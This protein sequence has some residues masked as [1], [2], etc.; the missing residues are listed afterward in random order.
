[1]SAHEHAVLKHVETAA[2]RTILRSVAGSVS[3]V[4]SG[5]G[6]DRRGL[7]VTAATSLCVEPPMVL[8]C[9]NRNA[10]AHDVILRTGAFSWNV[11]A[12]DQVRLAERFAAMD[13]S[14]GASRFTSADWHDLA[15]GAPVLLHSVC[16]FDCRIED[17]LQVSTH[18][19]IMGT[20]VAQ[21]HSHDKRPLIYA[22]GKFGSLEYFDVTIPEK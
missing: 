11:L 13:G 22:A 17:T 1:M 16:S 3:I 5:Q 8:A 21:S 2:F 14:K 20:V 6:P 9:I 18:T 12:A 19:I 15:T 7:T 4:A 10:E